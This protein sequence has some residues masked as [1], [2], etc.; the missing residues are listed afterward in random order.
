[1]RPIRAKKTKAWLEHDNEKKEK[2]REKNLRIWDIRK[3]FIWLSHPQRLHF[4]CDIE[5]N[6]QI[7]RSEV[8]FIRILVIFPSICGR[9]SPLYIACLQIL[10]W[11]ISCYWDIEMFCS[12]YSNRESFLQVGCSK[13]SLF[14][15]CFLY[16]KPESRLYGLTTNS[17][18]VFVKW[19]SYRN[20]FGLAKT[21]KGVAKECSK[22]LVSESWISELGLRF[23]S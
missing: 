22:K 20:K 16:N 10:H 18:W 21:F 19:G 13:F 14:W 2:K 5:P 15:E 4:S 11:Q 8:L 17:S 23:S 6:Y 7:P 12:T 1:M 9:F 3:I